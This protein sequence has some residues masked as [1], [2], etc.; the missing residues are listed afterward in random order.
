MNNTFGTQGFICNPIQP[1]SEAPGYEILYHKILPLEVFD[2][3]AVGSDTPG[4]LG[5]ARVSENDV[6]LYVGLDLVYR[7]S[8]CVTEYFLG[9]IDTTLSLAPGEELSLRIR[10]TQREKLERTHIDQREQILNFENTV[11]DN[12]VVS[13]TRSSAKQFN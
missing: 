9:E 5:A 13:A 6:H 7:Q 3:E 12:E 8:W 10:R 4:M 2:L 1:A 11:Q